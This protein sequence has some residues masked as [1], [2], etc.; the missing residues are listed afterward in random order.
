MVAGEAKELPTILSLQLLPLFPSYPLLH[1]LLLLFLL[2]NIM[3]ADATSRERPYWNY[4]GQKAPTPKEMTSVC[5]CVC[6][7]VCN[8]GTWGTR[9]QR[10]RNKK[11]QKCLLIWWQTS[12]KEKWWQTERIE[13]D[14]FGEGWIG[15][16]RM[17]SISIKKSEGLDEQR[18]TQ[19]L[20]IY[21]TLTW[22]Y[23]K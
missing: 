18:K 21:Y 8:G 1:L 6:V 3:T 16:R 5:A 22:A 17:A 14:V 20:V 12:L 15:P 19:A 11:I 2:N 13:R 10:T 7:C 9:A 23:G 4:R